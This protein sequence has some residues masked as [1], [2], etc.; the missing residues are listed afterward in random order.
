MT[1]TI[2]RAPALFRWSIE[3]G[4]GANGQIVARSY[5][6]ELA[7]VLSR[8][9]TKYIADRNGLLVPVRQGIAPVAWVGGQAA[10]LLEVASTNLCIR[11]QEI[12]TWSNTSTC[13]VTADAVL[14]PDGTLTADLVQ[15]T[16]T[17]SGRYR[18]VT[19]TGDGVKVFSAFIKEFSS[20]AR[21][22]LGIYDSTAAVN[23]HYVNVTWSGGVPSVATAFGSGTIYPVEELG[24]GWY[25]VSFSATGIIAANSHLLAVVPDRQNGTGGVFVWGVQTENAE[26][27]SSYI[28]TTVATVPRGVDSLYFPFTP[29]PQA[30]TVYARGIE[31][32]TRLTPSA[33]IWQVSQTNNNPRVH[34]N[35]T[36]GTARMQFQTVN[37][38]GSFST[39]ERLA[40]ADATVGAV[41]E[42]RAILS[43]NGTLGL[44]VTL[45]DGAEL[46][47]VPVA[48]TAL[49]SNWSGQRLWMGTSGGGSAGVFAFTHLAVM[50]GER[51]RG[52]MRALAGV[53]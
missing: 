43:S 45:N 53:V 1:A 50:A 41:S 46:V 48:G 16:V 44:G 35:R 51:D 10:L 29:I 40:G 13:N 28:P 12:D 36:S 52:T 47:S 24:R 39:V 20:S 26:V 25:R 9:S 22:Q 38:A 19:Y 17:D 2:R 21:T 14:A 31:R 6:T 3:D 5:N 30:M 8:P 11:S 15:A 33:Y 49:E 42:Y 32:G 34:L 37:T 23:R 27:P 4:I 18:G 7:G